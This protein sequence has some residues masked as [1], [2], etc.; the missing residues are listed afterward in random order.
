MCFLAFSDQYTQNFLSKAIY[1]FSHMLLQ[2]VRGEKKVC[3]HRGLNSQPPGHESDTLTTKPPGWG[4]WKDEPTIIGH[5]RI[6][7]VYNCHWVK[8]LVCNILYKLP[9]IFIS[10]SVQI[11]LLFYFNSLPNDKILDQSKLKAFAD[12]NLNVYKKLKFALGR[13]ENIVGKGENA[14]SPFRTMFSKGLFL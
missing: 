10:T 6:A 8:R 7:Q 3:L 1:Y 5:P 12:D 11:I 2:G 13:I 4:W 9:F 14:F